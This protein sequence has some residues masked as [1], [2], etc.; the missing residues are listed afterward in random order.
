MGLDTS[1]D[2][3]SG[4]YCSFMCW[5]TK[6]CEVAGYGN[7]DSRVGFGGD[8]PWPESDDVLIE[9]LDHSDCDGDIPADVCAPLADGRCRDGGWRAGAGRLFRGAARRPIAAVRG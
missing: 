1:Y 6:L 5:R 7:L 3:W 8:V 2:C 9:L 4:G